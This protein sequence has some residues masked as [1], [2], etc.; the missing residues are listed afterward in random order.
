MRL[1]IK[2]MRFLTLCLFVLVAGFALGQVFST[3]TTAS[4]SQ[5]EDVTFPVRGDGSSIFAD[6]AAAVGP[7]VV[8]IKTERAVTTESRGDSPFQFFREFMPDTPRRQRRDQGGGSGFVFDNEGRI[9]T[10]YHVVRDAEEITV[11]MA[12]GS[13]SKEYPA[14]VVGVDPATDIA[15]IKIDPPADMKIVPLGDSERV[16]VGDWVMAIGTP[17][18]QL[19]GTVTAGIVSAKGRSDLNIVGGQ[20]TIYQNYIQTD[21]SI[22]FGNSGGPL[23]NTR[24]E[25]IGINTAINPSGQGI[26]FAIPINMARQ[27]MEQLIQSG[28]VAYGYLGIQLQQLDATLAAGRGMDIDQGILVLRVL[29]E[30]PAAKAGLEQGDVIVRFDGE[31]VRDDDKFRLMVGNTPVGTSVP[32]EIVRGGD[33]KKLSVT[34]GERPTDNPLASAE[35]EKEGTWLGLSVDDADKREIRRQFNLDRGQTGVV[36]LGVDPGSPA[37]EAGIQE[38]DVITEVYAREVGS[39]KDYMSISESLKDRE[40]PIA[41]LVRRGRSTSY[42]PVIPKKR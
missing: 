22:N 2:S 3:S 16:R 41:F 13:E 24:G 15:I 14:E 31:E 11:V 20:E 29:P 23:V 40:K 39:L 1:N 4:P 42:V 30:A 5:D 18:G 32:V 35:P 7:G 6:V 21:A 17:F 10:N 33:R 9:L 19:Q 28:R 37:D 26:G 12:S 25:A 38:G 27:I 34:I 8:F 36:V